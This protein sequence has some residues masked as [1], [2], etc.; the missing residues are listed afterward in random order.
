VASFGVVLSTFGVMF[1]PN[2]EQAASEL[3]RV[4]RPGGKIR[5]A[6]WTPEGFIGTLFRTIGKYVPQA[7]SVKSP[8]RGAP[9]PI[10]MRRWSAAFLPA[11]PD[12]LILFSRIYRG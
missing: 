11:M 8:A 12:L 7:P 9:R 2:Q 4:C 5:L 6:N 1:T 10:G 3:L